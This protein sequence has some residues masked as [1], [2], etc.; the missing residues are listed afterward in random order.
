RSGNF[1]RRIFECAGCVLAGG[2][3]GVLLYD[4]ADERVEGAGGA[5]C[6][7]GRPHKQEVSRMPERD[8]YR[9]ATLCVLHVSGFQHVNAGQCLANRRRIGR[10]GKR[11]VAENGHSPW[12]KFTSDCP[13]A[14]MVKSEPIEEG[15]LSFRSTLAIELLHPSLRIDFPCSSVCWLFLCCLQSA[16]LYWPN[17]KRRCMPTA[18]LTCLPP[19]YAQPVSAT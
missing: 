10:V 3:C 17:R 12:L 1:L 8:P 4:R 18:P 5:Q 14:A 7:T 2:S 11:Q 19:R 13:G 16:C 15:T 9:R 6:S